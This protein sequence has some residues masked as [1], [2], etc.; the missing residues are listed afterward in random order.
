MLNYANLSDVDFEELAKDVM[1]QK[2]GIKLHTFAK[3]RDGGID[4]VDDI[5]Q[6]N[7]LIQVKHYYKSNFSNLK[8]TLIKEA[9][10]VNNLKPKQYYIFT[11]LSLTPKDINIIY[12]LFREY[13]KSPHHNIIHL[14]DIEN[15]LNEHEDIIKK[16]YK[17]WLSYSGILDKIKSEDVVIDSDSLK[18]KIEEHNNMYVKTRVFSEALNIL[19]QHRALLLVGPPGIGKTITS[20]MIVL[21]YLS[22]GYSVRY[23]T[24]GENLSGLKKSLSDNHDKKEIIFLDDCFGQCYFKMKDTQSNELLSLLMHVK[25]NNNKI[26]LLNS[27]V[28]ILNEAKK[29]NE[30]LSREI[31]NNKVKLKMLDIKD[32]SNVEKARIF[33]NHLFFNEIPQEYRENIRLNRGYLKIILHKNFTPRII[34]YITRKN[35]FKDIKPEKY[36]EFI[37]DKLNNPEGIWQNEFTNRLEQQD[38]ILLMILY[39]LTNTSIPLDFLKRCYNRIISKQASLDSTIDHFSES[40]KRLLG[41]FIDFYDKEDKIMVGVVNPS[42]NDFLKNYIENNISGKSNLISN[43]VAILQL[44]RLLPMKEAYSKIIELVKT[45]SILEMEFQ[46]DNEKDDYIIYYIATCQI[47]NKEYDKIIENFILNPHGIYMSIYNLFM[48]KTVTMRELLSQEMINFYNLDTFFHEHNYQIISDAT[49]EEDLESIVSLINKINHLFLVGDREKFI[50]AVY[51]NLSIATDR[52]YEDIDYFDELASN[53]IPHIVKANSDELTG[54]VDI[55][56]A[57]YG[58]V[59]IVGQ[60]VDCKAQEILGKLPEDILLEFEKRYNYPQFI[61]EAKD[62][63]EDYIR[64]EEYSCEERFKIGSNIEGIKEIIQIFER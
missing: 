54:E 64:S 60:E 23:T 43:A 14:N 3:G 4:I 36:T 53:I 52:F 35:V 11:S 29:N 27:R 47:K 57:E 34:E 19:D 9:K 24:D 33:Y 13:M 39:S 56:S 26:L 7:H 21:K 55:D 12:D 2:L 59:R 25:M 37:L 38:R 42:V 58:L 63:I 17:L 45:A 1:E 48:N 5:S 8:S 20:E 10:N 28:T 41:S 32:I 30:E 46:T 49:L 61:Y 6:C 40:I 22:E 18:C 16:H 50:D 44:V 15:F 62:L 31:G 51:K